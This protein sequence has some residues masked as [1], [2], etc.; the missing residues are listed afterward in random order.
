MFNSQKH[1]ESI[2]ADPSHNDAEQALDDA[3]GNAVPDQSRDPLELSRDEL[4]SVK[5]QLL[6]SVAEFQNFKRRVE[7]EKTDWFMFANEK[8]LLAMLPIVDDLERSLAAAK[9]AQ[10]EDP[11]Y[12][13]IEMIKQKLLKTLDG[14]GVRPIE[15]VGQPFNVDLHEALLQVQR[16]DVSPHTVVEEVQRGY[17]L[18]DKVLRHSQ[19]VVSGEKE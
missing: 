4:A 10:Q 6:R 17:Y 2:P 11:M 7:R 16:D 5:D 14:F 9:S 18:N 1:E 3:A 12:A 13:G 19:V 15:S 8:V